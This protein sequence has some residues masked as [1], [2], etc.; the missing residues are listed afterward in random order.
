MLKGPEPPASLRRSRSTT[1]APSNVHTPADVRTG[2]QDGPL[3]R[4]P[5]RT[6]LADR[7]WVPQGTSQLLADPGHL[8]PDETGPSTTPDPTVRSTRTWSSV[9]RHHAWRRRQLPSSAVVSSLAT[10]TALW[11]WYDRPQR[12]ADGVT[13]TP[14]PGDVQDPLGEGGQWL[15]IARLVAANGLRE[16][17]AYLDRCLEARRRRSAATEVS[18]GKQQATGEERHAERFRP[19]RRSIEQVP[20]KLGPGRRDRESRQPASARIGAHFDQPRRGQSLRLYRP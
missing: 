4:A 5:Y 9:V 11:P 1:S 18:S 16:P 17:V 14:L 15:F 10:R 19:R 2:D 3:L 6:E 7:R 12:L 13:S 8:S 20:M